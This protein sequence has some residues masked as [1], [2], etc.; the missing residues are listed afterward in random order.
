MRNGAPRRR[1]LPFGRRDIIFPRDIIF[2]PI[3]LSSAVQVV[4]A[5]VAR[6]DVLSQ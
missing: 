4:V 3:F 6:A 1:E 2:L 5:G